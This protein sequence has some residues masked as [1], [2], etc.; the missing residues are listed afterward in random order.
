MSGDYELSCESAGRVA[1]HSHSA[2]RRRWP[3]EL[4]A[5]IVAE[6]YAST[7]AE[8]AARYMVSTTQIF[9]WRRAARR[10]EGL[11]RGGAGGPARTAPASG[12]RF[13]GPLLVWAP[14]AW[15]VPPRTFPTSGLRQDR[16]LA[17]TAPQ[18][19]FYIED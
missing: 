10:A 1:V 5:Q 18:H 11:R 19:P 6:S 13:E 17:R 2:P 7:V 3:A 15:F 8:V 14:K 16:A 4:K 12:P 9:G